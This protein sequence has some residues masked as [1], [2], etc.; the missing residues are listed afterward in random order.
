MEQEILFPLESEVTLVTSF[1]DAD[2]M[3]VIYHG[4]YF[5]YFEEARRVMMDKI[6]YGYLAMNASGYMWPIIGTQVKY[7]KAIPFN[8]EIRVTAKLTEWENRLRVDYVIYDSKSGQRMCKGHT[9]QVAVAMET[10]E[11]CFASPKALTDK[12][13]YWHQHGRIAE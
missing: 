13:E 4:N 11:M 7:V 2:P 5:R 10:E 6:E 1:Q 8:H 12:I 9:M 3:G